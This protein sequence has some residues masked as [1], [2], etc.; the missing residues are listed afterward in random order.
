MQ[1]V[2]VQLPAHWVLVCGQA[3][4][5]GANVGAAV[6]GVPVGAVAAGTAD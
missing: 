1:V 5:K 6:V 3:R 4:P 2:H